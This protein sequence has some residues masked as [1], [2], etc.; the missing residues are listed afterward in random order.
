LIFV[1]ELEK[2]GDQPRDV[3]VGLARRSLVAGITSLLSSWAFL[4][5]VSNINNLSW[6]KRIDNYFALLIVVG[7][8]VRRRRKRYGD[9]GLR[10]N[11]CQ[12]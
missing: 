2:F 4:E 6:M 8:M 10:K 3:P 7:D 1:T 9:F 12:F 5:E 11:E